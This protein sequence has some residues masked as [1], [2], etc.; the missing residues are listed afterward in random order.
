MRLALYLPR[1][2]LTF[3]TLLPQAAAAAVLRVSVWACI[4]MGEETDEEKKMENQTRQP[5]N[6]TL[7]GTA[8][9][10]SPSAA[11][12]ARLRFSSTLRRFSSSRLRF[13]RKQI[14]R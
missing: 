10:C 2:G 5:I 4:N 14:R 6:R 9:S 11:A 12:A 3:A 1:L 8:A 7:T 13:L